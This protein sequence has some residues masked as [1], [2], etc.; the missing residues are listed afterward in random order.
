MSTNSSDFA[1]LRTQV[2]GNDGKRLSLLRTLGGSLLTT[3]QSLVI[4][5]IHL[6]WQSSQMKPR[7]CSSWQLEPELKKPIRNDFIRSTLL[8]ISQ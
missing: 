3:P 6:V 1:A 4:D 7:V 8:F 2:S 5:F